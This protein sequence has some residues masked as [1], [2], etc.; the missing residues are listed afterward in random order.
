M[1]TKNLLA[2]GCTLA[3]LFMSAQSQAVPAFARSN[4]LRCAACHS[5]FPSLNSD[6]RLFKTR[7]YRTEDRKAAKSSD[8]TTDLK[9]FPI[10][11]AIISRPY[12]KD[13]DGNS[14]IR[15]IH[16]VELF[17]GGVFYKNLS[18]FVEI[19]SEGEDG[20]GD[21]LG[22]A[23]FNYDFNDAAHLRVIVKSGV[24]T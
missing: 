19:E 23:S 5:A 8:F 4:N 21:V 2:A 6:G 17:V 1:K 12:A 3:M 22:V 11:A 13:S 24:R 18:G 14:E 15:A 20:F 10:S 9:Q 16:E 7:G